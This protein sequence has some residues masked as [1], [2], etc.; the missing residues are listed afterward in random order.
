M[1]CLTS[2]GN[3][4]RLGDPHVLLLLLTLV[5]EMVQAGGR[6][7]AGAARIIHPVLWCDEVVRR[8][9]PVEVVHRCVLLRLCMR[10]S[11][12]GKSIRNQQR[13]RWSL[14]RDHG[15]RG[16]RHA[17][18]WAAN[19]ARSTVLVEGGVGREVTGGGGATRAAF[20]ACSS[21]VWR[22]VLSHASRAQPLIM[23]QRRITGSGGEEAAECRVSQRRDGWP[24]HGV[25]GWARAMRAVVGPRLGRAGRGKWL[26]CVEGLC[27]HRGAH[28]TAPKQGRES[29]ESN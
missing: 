15:V 4:N 23:S 1:D 3:V 26:P 11:V 24:L 10:G 29:G 17:L 27:C 8:S 25:G 13:S 28:C 7:K 20:Q 6:V 19:G 5:E 16:G 12:G 18:A 21:L 2:T 22:A 14:C 9:P